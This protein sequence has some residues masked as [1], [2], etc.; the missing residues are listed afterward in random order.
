M[1]IWNVFF[2]ALLGLFTLSL[3]SCL[4]EGTDIG[5]ESGST[6]VV[7][8]NSNPGA[9]SRL[10]CD[11]PHTNNQ[12]ARE[13]GFFGNVYYIPDTSICLGGP[14]PDSGNSNGNGMPTGNSRGNG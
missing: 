10:I 3:S 11:R 8:P 13:R 4:V 1:R 14:N 2:V 12:L 7:D 5:S 6:G 9:L